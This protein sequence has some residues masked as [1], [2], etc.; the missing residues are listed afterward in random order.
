MGTRTQYGDPALRAVLFDRDGTL[1]TDVPYNGDPALVEP[2]PTAA[3]A[4][5]CLRRAASPSG[6]ITNQSGVGARP[7]QPAESRP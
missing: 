4:T 7:P 2:M 3:P 1:S 6:S 5:G